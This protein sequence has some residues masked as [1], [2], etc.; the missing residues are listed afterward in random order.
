M[1]VK[2]SF[3]LCARLGHHLVVAVQTG[4]AFRLARLGAGAHPLQ[5]VGQALR[6]LLVALLLGGHT[7][8]LGLQVRGVVALVGV[9]VAAVDL[10]DPL[11]HVVQEVAVVRDGEHGAFVVVQELLQPQHAFGVQVVGRLVEQQQVGRLQQQAAQ[12]HAAALAAREHVD[13]HVGVGALQRVHRL[14][15]LAVQIPA[16][17]GV[18][19]VLELAHLV[20]ELVE[21]RVGI[22]HLGAD[23]VE[24]LNF[25][26]NV[27][28]R[29]LDVLKDGLV[30]VQRRLLLQDAHGVAGRQARLA[31]G[32]LLEARHQLEQRGLAHAVGA[33]HADLGAGIKRQRHVVQDHLVAVR[34][35]RL[36]HLVDEFRHVASCLPIRGNRFGCRCGAATAPPVRLIVYSRI[37]ARGARYTARTRYSTLPSGPVM[38]LSTTPPTSKPSAASAALTSSTTRSRTAA[39]RTTPWSVSS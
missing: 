10:A 37:Q 31:V 24:T 2:S 7:G 5:L 28:E 16:V 1:D 11:G 9:E 14:R 12:R 27:G 20:H 8:G 32:D 22:G 34:L 17:L 35:A 13:R 23:L 30:L 39:S 19:L 29:H 6:Q 38:G 18:D 21:I 3:L 33:H 15:Q 26:Q 4:A 25:G 36:V